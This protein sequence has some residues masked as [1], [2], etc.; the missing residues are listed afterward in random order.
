[1]NPAVTQTL[2][3]VLDLTAQIATVGAAVVPL[4]LP[5]VPLI[6]KTVSARIKDTNRRRAFEVV[7]QAGSVATSVAAA[8]VARKLE[9]ARSPSSRGGTTITPEERNEALAAGAA[10]GWHWAKDQMPA[11]LLTK[12]YGD[13]RTVEDCLK[14][15]ARQ[16]LEGNPAGLKDEGSTVVLPTGGVQ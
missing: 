15:K 10:A 6:I 1:M 5:L 4:V 7:G 11:E 16:N 12:V 3:Q 9:E 8:V 13:Q 14:A 2:Y